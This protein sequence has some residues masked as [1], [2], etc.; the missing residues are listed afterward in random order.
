MG[1]AKRKGSTAPVNESKSPATP[2]SPANKQ[3]TATLSDKDAIRFVFAAR[4][5]AKIAIKRVHTL[6]LHYVITH[7]EVHCFDSKGKAFDMTTHPTGETGIRERF[8]IN[9]SCTKTRKILTIA[10]FFKTKH[11]LIEMKQDET[12]FN[13]LKKCKVQI[14]QHN[15][16]L[17]TLELRSIGFI[18]K[19]NPGH[20]NVSV[21][22]ADIEKYM[23][24]TPHTVK[25]DLHYSLAYS[26]KD[27]STNAYSF[28]VA[29][30]DMN[31]AVEIMNKTNADPRAPFKFIAYKSKHDDPEGYDN[32]INA[33][34]VISNSQK[35]VPLIG[36]NAKTMYTFGK[37]YQSL[38]TI[39]RNKREAKEL[40]FVDIV[41]TN[42]T[43]THGR[44]NVI[45]KNEDFEKTS[46]YLKTHVAEFSKS[47]PECKEN[48]YAADNATAQ[49]NEYNDNKTIIEFDQTFLNT[50][51]NSEIATLPISR[52]KV[53]I[54][55]GSDTSSD[56]EDKP[57]TTYI[58][59]LLNK[60]TGPT[61]TKDINKSIEIGSQYTT[62]SA[63]S[64]ELEE[65]RTIITN[66]T[67][68]IKTMRESQQKEQK[69]IKEEQ[70]KFNKDLAE[71]MTHLF[72]NMFQ[73]FRTTTPQQNQV[74]NNSEEQKSSDDNS[75]TMQITPEDNQTNT[76]PDP[77]LVTDK[78]RK[79]ETPEKDYE[80]AECSKKQN[81]NSTPLKEPR[82]SGRNDLST[83]D[84]TKELF[85]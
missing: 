28:Q 50:L 80:I 27:N 21:A 30:K 33:Q 41:K 36:I 29:K 53:T 16:D 67:Q 35:V 12:F 84:V 76:S 47:H 9:E 78:S 1:R 73:Q 44:W 32:A 20:K 34:N 79:R 18:L 22:S 64:S 61:K 23:D 55:W 49:F 13:L 19:I 46:T 38:Q 17:E 39:L 2:S 69:I 62:I 82:G 77:D 59:K 26:T 74:N 40:N 81:N 8:A 11:S 65:Q 3:N 6:L 37:D 25:F 58:D 63:L 72:N 48:E 15:W 4:K 60:N 52:P 70:R 57:N 31:T 14:H 83:G 56:S 43:K 5:D 71:H 10:H 45:V 51:T 24:Q 54:D 42:K 85:K 75:H 7:F 68:E 66:L